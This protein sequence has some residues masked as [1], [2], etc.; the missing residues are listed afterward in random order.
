M[1][2]LILAHRTGINNTKFVYYFFFAKLLSRSFDRMILV[3]KEVWGGG[4][5]ALQFLVT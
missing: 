2:V 3:N 5:V 4:L 1:H